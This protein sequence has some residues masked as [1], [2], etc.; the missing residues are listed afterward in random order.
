[1][2][3]KEGLWGLE[4]LDFLNLP[5]ISRRFH[6][7]SDHEQFYIC[8]TIIYVIYVLQNLLT[9]AQLEIL[10][11]QL[12]IESESWSLHPKA[13]D[14]ASMAYP[15]G[16]WG[17]DSRVLHILTGTACPHGYCMSSR[18]LHVLTGTA[19]PHGYCMSSRV[20]HV[21]TG[22]AC[23][24]GYCMSS[25][26]LHILTGTA[27]SLHRVITCHLLWHCFITKFMMAGRFFLWW[28]KR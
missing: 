8:G 1:M 23:P 27:Y 5:L 21:L 19:C 6:D 24:H 9:Q 22:T 13:G 17:Y 10:L 16:Y 12:E 26:V 18:V 7:F 28:T 2:R 25:R 14:L 4:F 3:R 11:A 20:L 15:H